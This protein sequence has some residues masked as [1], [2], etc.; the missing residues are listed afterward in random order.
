MNIQLDIDDI[1]KEL[2]L[3]QN[4]ADL[5]VSNG[6]DAVTEEIYRNWR[7]EA[8]NAL[9]STRQDYIDGLQVI[10]NS[11]YSKTIKLNGVLNNMIEE[12]VNAFDMKEG[13]SKSPKAKW[14]PKTDKN[15]NVT[16]HWYLTVPFRHG[17]PTTIG[18]NAAF[19]GV[20]PNAVYNVIK[21]SP[22]KKGLSAS[23][24]PHPYDI[25]QKRD[26][27]VI[28][29]KNIN[30]PEY[31]HKHSIYEG[32]TRPTGAYGKTSQNTYVSFRR[33]SE[34]SDPDSWIHSGIKAHK[35]LDKAIAETDIETIVENNIDETL[36]NLGYG[37]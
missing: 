36:A 7:L 31:K 28:P 15:G 23:A 2:V 32:L 33:V 14:S 27:I 18:D 16:L 30:I 26:A 8:T 34:N 5:I 37:I 13:F 9:T 21:N 20:M 19:S 11:Q 35:L 3:P 12:G 1:I 6:V 4:V 17:V 22:A 25:P 29:S 24:I 10:N